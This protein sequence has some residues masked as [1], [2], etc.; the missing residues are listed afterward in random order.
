MT[1]RRRIVDEA[2]DEL[3]PH[4]AAIS[5][6]S[7]K[8]V[9]KTATATERVKTVI[10][11]DNPAQHEIVSA[12]LSYITQVPTP[13]LIDEWQPL[14]RVWDR[15]RRAVDAD[16]TGSQFL[17]AGSAEASPSARIHSGAGRIVRL[18]MRPLSL[19]ERGLLMP[20][21]SLAELLTGSRPTIGGQSGSTSRRT[22][23]RSSVRASRD[24]GNSRTDHAKNSSTVISGA[25]WRGTSAKMASPP[26]GHL[27]TKETDNE[28]DL[29]VEGE[30]RNVVA[31]EVWLR[32]VSRGPCS[33]SKR[34]GSS[35][36]MKLRAVRLSW[37]DLGAVEVGEG[38]R[39]RR[40]ALS[41]VARSVFG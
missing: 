36:A 19:T 26:G 7:A 35:A 29:I 23:T 31:I 33:A 13:V 37:S 40:A 16:N 6:E 38:L 21:V 41:L 1:Y 20:T 2:L 14:E 17:L 22:P 28:I 10:A 3:F 8:G 15:V 24:C 27:R 30:D 25:S 39:R 4:L 32:S 18:T 5:L 34:S 11:L 12:D 9:G